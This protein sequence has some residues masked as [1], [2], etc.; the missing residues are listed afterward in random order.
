L[1]NRLAA[2]LGTEAAFAGELHHRSEHSIEL[3]AVWLH[4]ARGGRAVEMLPV[5]VGDLDALP[6][7]KLDRF[8]ETLQRETR[9]RRTLVVAAGDLAHVGPAFGGEPVTP[10]TLGQ[11]R[12]DDDSILNALDGH[13]PEALRLQLQA[14]A[15][16]NVCGA[17]PLYLTNRILGTVHT[18]RLGYAACPADEENASFVTIAGAGLY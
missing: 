9:R 16:N 8:V 15:S 17:H 7:G 6:A 2:V 18:D 3:A 4:F 10:S 11:L 13:P 1:V 12:E 14:T 5:L